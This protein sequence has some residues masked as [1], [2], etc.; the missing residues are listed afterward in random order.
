[1]IIQF[2]ISVTNLP[3]HAFEVATHQEKTL[4]QTYS[5]EDTL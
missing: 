4:S 3:D 2:I 1:M 5:V